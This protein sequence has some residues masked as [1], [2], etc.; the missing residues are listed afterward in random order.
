[1]KKLLIAAAFLG[2]M[3]AKAQAGTLLDTPE[4]PGSAQVS[5]DYG[6]VSYSSVSYSSANVLCFTGAGVIHWIHISSIPANATP[7]A[8]FIIVRD[9]NNLTSG[10]V[11]GGPGVDPLTVDYSVSGEAFRLNISTVTGGNCNGSPADGYT[12]W[13][14][15]PIRLR[16]GGAVKTNVSN[17]N[18]MT[19]GWTNFGVQ[20]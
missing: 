6:G 18:R 19:I 8:D 15:P 16:K 13:F 5:A 4:A 3:A 11:S 9:T 14:A 20:Q 12:Y 2:L 17:Y 1:M 7:G 10:A